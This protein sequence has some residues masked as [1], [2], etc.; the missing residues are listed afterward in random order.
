M[1]NLP[2]PKKRARLGRS[3]RRQV[4]CDYLL[5]ELAVQ[6]VKPERLRTWEFWDKVF[7]AGLKEVHRELSAEESA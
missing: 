1:S 3:D 4:P 2:L 6:Q 7:R 5:Y